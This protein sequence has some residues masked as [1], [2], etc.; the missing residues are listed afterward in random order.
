[1]PRLSRASVAFLGMALC[2]VSLLRAQPLNIDLSSTVGTPSDVFGAAANQPGRWNTVGLGATSNLLAPSGA[3]T[4]VDI[5]V[6]AD[7]DDGKSP[8][9]GG[10]LDA[11]IADNI[12]SDGSTSTWSVFL[13]GLADREYSV[14]LYGPT[15]PAVATGDMIVN[16]TPV[17][18]ITGNDCSLTKGLTFVS[19]QTTVSGGTLSITGD[20]TGTGFDFVGLSGLQVSEVPIF[21]DGFETGDTSAWSGSVP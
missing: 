9:C 17:P 20:A 14:Y 1:M 10:D 21:S 5:T 6:T 8:G 19:V 13:S 15:N 16:G 2:G 18:S 4:S 12:F 11:L 3:P 7:F